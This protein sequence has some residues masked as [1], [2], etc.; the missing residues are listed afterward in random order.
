MRPLPDGGDGAAVILFAPARCS[1]KACGATRSGERTQP[2]IQSDSV[3]QTLLSGFASLAS[4]DAKQRQLPPNFC[5]ARGVRCYGVGLTEAG[6]I[7][8]VN[9]IR[10]SFGIAGNAAS[11]RSTTKVRHR[12]LKKTPDP[13]IP[14]RALYPVDPVASFRSCPFVRIHRGD[15]DT[16][17]KNDD[18][19]LAHGASTKDT[20][21]WFFVAILSSMNPSSSRPTTTSPDR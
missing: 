6:T 16:K 7:L 17:S 21:L 4:A 13:F 3:G 18:V 12:I 15:A 8:P 19:N 1:E 20:S 10:Y 14:S 2:S 5:V 11:L 9:P